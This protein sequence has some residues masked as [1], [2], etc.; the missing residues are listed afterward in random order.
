MWYTG[1]FSALMMV[2][3]S[4]IGISDTSRA[5]ILVTTRR[6]II[7]DFATLYSLPLRP[8]TSFRI[9]AFGFALAAISLTSTPSSQPVYEE[10][11]TVLGRAA[12][13]EFCVET[14]S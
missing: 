13:G 14:R 10:F 6:C 1:L 12:D 2:S 8:S 5:F 3:R 4:S 11:Q 9:V 7:L